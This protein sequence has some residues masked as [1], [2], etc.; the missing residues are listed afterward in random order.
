MIELQGQIVWQ[1][2]SFKNANDGL[3]PVGLGTTTGPVGRLGLRGQWTIDDARGV[4][5]QPYVGANVWHSWGAEATTTFDVDRVEL[6]QN[7]TRTEVLTGITARLDQRL[8]LYA[9]ASYQFVRDHADHE[10][11]G[12]AQGN[13][14]LRFSW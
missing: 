3:G 2:V 1:Q 9:Q 4:R 14:G 6:L 11:R 7:L 5:W 12:A 8:S 10:T 13:V